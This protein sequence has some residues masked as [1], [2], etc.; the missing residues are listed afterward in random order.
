MDWAVTG[1][2]CRDVQFGPRCSLAVVEWRPSLF[3]LPVPPCWPVAILTLDEL[4]D[5]GNVAKIGL[6]LFE[7]GREGSAL[8]IED[9]EGLAQ[10]VDG[11]G[12][13]TGATDA[14]DVQAGHAVVALLKNEWRHVLGG[15]ASASEHG[16]TANSDPLLNR[17]MAGE[18][19]VVLECHMTAKQCVIDH[20]AAIADPNVVA[21]VATDHEHVPVADRG[22]SV[23]LHGAAMNGHKLAEDIVVADLNPCRLASVTAM[24]RALA[25]HCPVADEVVP[26]HDERTA[27]APVGFDH[28]TRTD[29]HRTVDD[30]IGTNLHVWCDYGVGVD[31][32]GRMDEF[33]IE[34]RHHPFSS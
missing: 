10:R 3:V 29:L 24:L 33:R 4:D 1:A 18:D 30:C 27:Q 26:P 23:A 9:S 16:Q 17:R 31:H 20:R 8:A 12:R 19:A 5:L 13:E 6:D 34:Q 21:D 15:A 2:W 7:R 11:L 14:D 25:Q 28:A 32:G 22:H